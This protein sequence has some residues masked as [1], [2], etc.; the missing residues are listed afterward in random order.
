MAAVDSSWLI[1]STILGAE[2]I[3]VD[4]T[5]VSLTADTYYL[6]DPTA[7]RSLITHFGTQVVAAVGGTCDLVI[8]R[9]RKVRITFN[10]A[11]SVTWTGTV[12]RDLL[13]FTG[14]L[15]AATTHTAPNISP[16]LWSPG[17]PATPATIVGVEGY[18]RDHKVVAKSDDGTVAQ[19]TFFSSETWQD[20][21]WTHIVASRMRHLTVGGGTFH[22][23]YEQ[24]LKLG[25]R[26]KHYA[27]TEDSAST[28]AATI[29]T[30]LGPYVLRAGFSGDWY[31]RRVPTADIVSPLKLPLHVV[32]DA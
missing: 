29:P 27:V 18:S 24:S 19:V 21:S 25:Y 12:L 1:G 2:A 3:T 22:E 28:T 11:R 31:T 30:G 32:E 14:N 15:A 5:A 7:G 20:L 4:A 17:F 16:L 13:G 8:Q 26:C 6:Y 23:F 9:D 10:T